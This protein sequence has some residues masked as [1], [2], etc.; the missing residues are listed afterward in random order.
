HLCSR[1]ARAGALVVADLAEFFEVDGVLLP[2]GLRQDAV[3][4]RSL[5]GAEIAGEQ[6]DGALVGHRAPPFGPRIYASVGGC[7][8]PAASA[9]APASPQRRVTSCCSISAISGKSPCP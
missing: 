6:G 8:R 1:G 5:A 9:G 4:Q 2:L 7:Y 3:E